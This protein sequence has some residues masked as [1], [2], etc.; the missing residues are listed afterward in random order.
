MVDRPPYGF[1]NVCLHEALAPA[2]HL[3][4]LFDLRPDPTGVPS[5]H[6]TFRFGRRV[7]LPST[8]SIVHELLVMER[9]DSARPRESAIDPSSNA[10]RGIEPKGAT[11]PPAAAKG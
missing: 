4:R 9:D 3:D 5:M 6:E 8:L 7:P 11:P 10:V 2:C 1:A